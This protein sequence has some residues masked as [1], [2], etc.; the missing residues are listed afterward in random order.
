[1]GVIGERAVDDL[2]EA[3]VSPNPDSPIMHMYNV[4]GTWEDSAD[5][6]FE[7]RLPQGN[8]VTVRRT[9]AMSAV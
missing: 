2:D 6:W 9:L 3:P 8:M 1:M 7:E 4:D 5:H